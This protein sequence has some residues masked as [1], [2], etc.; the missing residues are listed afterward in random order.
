MCGGS[1][2]DNLV[3]IELHSLEIDGHN[4]P[5]DVPTLATTTAPLLAESEMD[6][7]EPQPIES[8]T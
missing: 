1:W 8:E 4:R 3:L 6:S 7:S 5:D 2:K